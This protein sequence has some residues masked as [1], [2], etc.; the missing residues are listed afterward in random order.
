MVAAPLVAS[1]GTPCTRAMRRIEAYGLPQDVEMVQLF[2]SGLLE[3]LPEDGQVFVANGICAARTDEQIYSFYQHL[4]THLCLAIRTAN[5]KQAFEDAGAEGRLQLFKETCFSR[6]NHRCVVSLAIDEALWVD[7]GSC[8]HVDHARL[9]ATH[10]IPYGYGT[11]ASAADRLNSETHWSYLQHCFPDTLDVLGAATIDS[12]RNG[13]TLHRVIREQFERFECAFKPDPTLPHTYEFITF[14]RFA[15]NTK[16][17]LPILP[18]RITLRPGP[19]FD[20]AYLPDPALFNCHYRLATFFH[21][22]G[23]GISVDSHLELWKRTLRAFAGHSLDARG[24]DDIEEVFSHAPW[25]T[26]PE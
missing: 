9:E 6:D 17:L 12:A 26:V 18:T 13:I 1:Q 14:P 10:I 4:Y 5:I 11:F 8:P 25:G 3:L 7:Q 22:Y 21:L 20:E 23:I 2:L 15:Q 16:D 19:T 24:R